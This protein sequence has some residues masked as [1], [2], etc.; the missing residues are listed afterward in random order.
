MLSPTLG[1]DPAKNTKQRSVTKFAKQGHFCQISSGARFR[2]V[3]SCSGVGPGIFLENDRGPFV[4][5]VA[6]S[7]KISLHRFFCSQ[8]RPFWG[9]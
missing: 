2:G 3:K 7:D 4:L 8:K 6:F 9:L 5:K 1:C